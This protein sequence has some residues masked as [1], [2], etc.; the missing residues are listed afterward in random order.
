MKKKV[1]QSENK[2][3]GELISWGRI[4]KSSRERIYKSKYTHA[5][6][7]M[8]PMYSHMASY[9]IIFHS[10]TEKSFL[11]INVKAPSADHSE[12]LAFLESKQG[13][14]MDPEEKLPGLLLLCSVT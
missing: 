12:V 8:G 10:W 3:V 1:L 13:A 7:V 5:C 4:L 11:F 2:Q 14:L 9:I 6:W